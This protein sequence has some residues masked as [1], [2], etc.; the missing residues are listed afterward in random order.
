MGWMQADQDQGMSLESHLGTQY[1][2]RPLSQGTQAASAVAYRAVSNGQIQLCKPVEHEPWIDRNAKRRG[3]TLGRLERRTKLEDIVVDREDDSFVNCTHKFDTARDSRFQFFGKVDVGDTAHTIPYTLRLPLSSI[4]DNDSHVV[5]TTGLPTGETSTLS[6]DLVITSL[7]FH[8][9]PTANF[10]DLGLGYLRTVSGRIV[11]ISGTILKNVY[12]SDTVIS[13]WQ[14]N[15]EE[16]GQNRILD[17]EEPPQEVLKA[18][19][20]RLVTE[21]ADWKKI[22]EVEVR[23]GEGIG[24]ERERMGWFEASKFLNKLH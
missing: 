1:E 7:G 16:D 3:R 22:G 23:R 20:E 15:A 5:S 24:K 8:G 14:S 9:E 19:K 13:D 17:L 21:Y 10:Y 12:A 2:E 4:F 11:T 6:T 18:L